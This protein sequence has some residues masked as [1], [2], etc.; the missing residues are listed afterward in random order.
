LLEP[1]FARKLEEMGSAPVGN[2]P[3]EFAAF[4]KQDTDRWRQVVKAAGI[5][6]P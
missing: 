5:V 1:E 3:E 4:I 6:M 2:T